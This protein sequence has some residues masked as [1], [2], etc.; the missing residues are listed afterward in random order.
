MTPVTP[1]EAIGIAVSQ[2]VCGILAVITFLF[3]RHKQKIGDWK[4]V[5]NR[6][7]IILFMLLFFGLMAMKFFMLRW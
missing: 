3:I 6:L 5:Q 4:G 2:I 1:N 7:G